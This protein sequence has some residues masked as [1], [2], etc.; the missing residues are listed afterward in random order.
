MHLNTQVLKYDTTSIV[1][2]Y[3][4]KV[5][6]RIFAIFC[7]LVFGSI[8]TA[9]AQVQVGDKKL[10]VNTQGGPVCPPPNN[11]SVGEPVFYSFEF[12]NPSGSDELVSVTEKYPTSFTLDNTTAPATC[13]VTQGATQGANVAVTLIPPAPVASPPFQFKIIV[14]SNSKVTCVI[15]GYF[16]KAGATAINTVTGPNNDDTVNTVVNSSNVLPTDLSI[17][18]SVVSPLSSSINLSGGPQTVRYRIEISTSKDIYLGDY[19]QIFDQLQLFPSSIPIEATYDVGSLKCYLASAGSFSSPVCEEGSVMSGTVESKSPSWQDFVSWGLLPN[20][21]I[22]LTTGDTL[23]LEYDVVYEVNEDFTCVIELDAEGINNHAFLGLAGNGQAISDDDNSNNDTI[24]TSAL[25][26][27]AIETGIYNVDPNCV[28]IVGDAP[29]SPLILEKLRNYPLSWGP[30]I[31]NITEFFR[32]WTLSLLP[33]GAASW[34]DD[35]NY[36]IRITNTSTTETITKIKLED[37]IINLPSTPNFKVTLTEAKFLDCPTGSTCTQTKPNPPTP[38]S[39]P[40]H[41]I[42]SYYDSA[43]IWQAN[44]NQLAP[45]ESAVMKVVAKIGEPWCD[46]SS[47]LKPKNIR[48][49]ITAKYTYSNLCSWWPR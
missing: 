37:F 3:R 26:P 28:P 46:A 2:Q 33:G 48:N 14:P 6:C 20:Q 45:G 38:P 17:K 22:L 24:N 27:I 34:G 40:A 7:L 13:T 30:S 16:N 5:F 19:I 21:S 8:G 47:L 39:G 11:P 1:S 29:A 41:N 15:A 25:T 49:R 23:V 9:Y 32:R 4:H 10:C 36:Y 44:I 18:K 12:D 31:P 35:V 43:S 42:L